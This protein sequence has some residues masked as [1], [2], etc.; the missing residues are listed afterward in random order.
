MTDDAEELI[1]YP[2]LQPIIDSEATRS[3]FA[4]LNSQ[5]QH[6]TYKEL[7]DDELKVIIEYLIYLD[8]VFKLYDLEYD[9]LDSQFILSQLT[10]SS[11]QDKIKHMKQ[12][13]SIVSQVELVME[14]L[15]EKQS[16]CL[17]ELGAGR[18]KLSLWLEQA[19]KNKS[20]RKEVKTNFLLVERGSQK[21]KADSQIKNDLAAGEHITR[22]R[23]DLKDLVIGKQELIKTSDRYIMYG[24]HLCGVATDFSL[25]CLRKSI[26]SEDNKFKGFL[27]AVCC[28]HKCEYSSMCGRKFLNLLNIDSNLFYVIRSL[29]SWSTS[30][31][32]GNI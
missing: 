9:K 31:G 27:L 18:G 21:L 32:E 5:I 1:D 19:W 10:E 3:H 20:A 13:S 25:R 8:S 28:H 14:E 12:I 17:V 23:L 30:G 15:E 6:T 22:V 16:C 2:D 4:K 24:K 26:Q 29:T 7:N 11:G